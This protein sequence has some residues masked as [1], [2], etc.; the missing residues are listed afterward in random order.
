MRGMGVAPQSACREYNGIL[1][2][3]LS[4][5]ITTVGLGVPEK[6]LREMSLIAIGTAPTERA[7]GEAMKMRRYVVLSSCDLG[8]GAGTPTLSLVNLQTY[9]TWGAYPTSGIQAFPNHPAHHW[10]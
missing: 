7:E 1:F 10:E 8:F 9:I 6:C 4:E 2:G 5:H 3:Q